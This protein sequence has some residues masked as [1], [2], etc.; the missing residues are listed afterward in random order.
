MSLQQAVKHLKDNALMNGKLGDYMG[1][2]K[3]AM[4]PAEGN[5]EKW[6]KM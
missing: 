5:Q 2:K 6:L 4:I 3:V 1:E